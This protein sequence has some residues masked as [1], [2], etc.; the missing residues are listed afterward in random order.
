[1]TLVLIVLAVPTAWFIHNRIVGYLVLVAAQSF[2]FTFQTGLLVM[3]WV[4]GAKQAFGPYPKVS[5]GD[6]WS[7]GVVNLAIFAAQLG[8]MALTYKLRSK[9]HASEPVAAGGRVQVPAH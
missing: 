2:L 7:Y 5:H 9:G 4:G 1:M 6:V 8:A 3:E